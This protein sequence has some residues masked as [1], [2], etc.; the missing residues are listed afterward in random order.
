MAVRA[1]DEWRIYEWFDM[2]L[3]F[4]YGTGPLTA[5]E[6]ELPRLGNSARSYAFRLLFQNNTGIE[7]RQPEALINALLSFY[8]ALLYVVSALVEP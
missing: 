5:L 4:S 7:T 6:A 1:Q 2:A 8:L 3:T